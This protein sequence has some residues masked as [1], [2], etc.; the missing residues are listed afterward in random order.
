MNLD[1]LRKFCLSLEY[2]SEDM[3]FDNETLVFRVKNKIFALTNIEGDFS[4]NLKCDPQKAL[5]LRASYPA[6]EP[7]Y[8]MNKTHWN[9]VYCDNS[10][11]DELIFEW[12]QHSYDLVFKSLPKK[13]CL[14][15]SPK[16]I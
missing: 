1:K 14:I 8:H 4:V 2:T 10:I 9:T 5:E 16:Q 15:C 7:G 11:E 12:I 6:V 13:G 3:P